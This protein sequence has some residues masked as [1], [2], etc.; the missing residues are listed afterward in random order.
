[1]IKIVRTEDEL[2]IEN[3]ITLV[4]FYADWCG[5]CKMMLPMLEEL[6]S[7]YPDIT[8]LKVNADDFPELILKHEVTNVPTLD[9]YDNGTRQSRKVGYVPKQLLLKDLETNTSFKR[10]I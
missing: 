5:P 9:I 2:N 4:D 10:K 1:M 7:V 3:G 6:D 8:I